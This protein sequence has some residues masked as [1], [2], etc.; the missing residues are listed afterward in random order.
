MHLVCLLLFTACV[1]VFSLLLV[2][3]VASVVVGEAGELQHARGC[4]GPAHSDVR[5]QEGVWQG[6]RQLVVHS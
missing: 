2:P 4:A 1:A 5:C 3:D 6:V